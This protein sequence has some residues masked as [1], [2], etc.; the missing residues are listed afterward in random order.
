MRGLAEFVMKGRRQ[1]IIAVLL[2][3]LVPLVYFLSPVVVGLVMLRKGFREGAQIF[4]WAI[5]PIGAWAYIG[6]VWPLLMLIGV[7]GMAILLRETESWEFTL[8]AGV[9]IGVAGEMYLRMQPQVLDL[10]FLQLE[11]YLESNQ[12]QGVQLEDLRELMTGFIGAVY[13]F[14]AA[15]LLMLSRW[16]Q[17]ALFN[18]GGFQTEFHRLR[19]EQKVALALLVAMLLANFG[20]L[21][22]ETWVLYLLMPLLLAGLALCH[23]VV[24][25]RGMSSS[26]LVALYAL[27]VFPI[28]IQLLVLLALVDSWYDF[29]QRL[30]QPPQPPVE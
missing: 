6:D 2:L 29:R 13:M 26:W 23:G 10:V 28:V 30:Q 15:L 14:L 24:K 4:A 8:L 19:I 9:L 1:A 3:G 25:L 22:P 27:M 21:V 7:S 18:P 5:L 20:V 11:Q 16:M 12:L 17:A